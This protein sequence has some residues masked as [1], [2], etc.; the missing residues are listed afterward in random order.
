MHYFTGDFLKINFCY[1]IMLLLVLA[2]LAL[3][4]VTIGCSA[5]CAGV[6]CKEVKAPDYKCPEINCG[7]TELKDISCGDTTIGEMKCPVVQFGGL[8]CAALDCPP[9]K[10]PEYKCSD[11]KCSN[12]DI[13]CPSCV[14]VS[15]YSQK[16]VM[17]DA[18]PALA[19]LFL[20]LKLQKWSPAGG[21]K[22]NLYTLLPYH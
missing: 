14:D 5:S 8:H 11:V 16:T 22:S 18:V 19:M 4:D 1:L 10:M 6:D 3:I 17:H 15:G 20:I 2:L 9:I 13:K 12:F 7:K 21:P